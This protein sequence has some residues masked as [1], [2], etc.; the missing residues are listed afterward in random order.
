M[1]AGKAEKSPFTAIMDVRPK[2]EP[3]RVRKVLSVT[4]NNDKTCFA[5]GLEEGFM[6]EWMPAGP[7][8]VGPW[9]RSCSIL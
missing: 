4:F 2:I 9:I 1:T 5:I 6:G 3:V 7:F 8:L